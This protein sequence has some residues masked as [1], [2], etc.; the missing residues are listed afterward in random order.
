MKPSTALQNH[1]DSAREIVLSHRVQNAR[2]FGSVLHGDDADGSDLD[3]LV[4]PTTETTL[5]DIGAIRLELR[6][7][8]GV[9]VEV[10]TPR[11]LPAK[12]RQR[13]LDEAM[14]L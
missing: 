8:L 10:L 12:F 11:A 1:R 9:S 3:I 4:D 2:I 6:D 5:M 13:V 14:P 7:L